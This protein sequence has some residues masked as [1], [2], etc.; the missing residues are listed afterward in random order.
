MSCDEQ[1]RVCPYGIHVGLYKYI[2]LLHLHVTWIQKS[3]LFINIIIEVF[4]MVITCLHSLIETKWT[5]CYLLLP[6]PYPSCSS[7][8]LLGRWQRPTSEERS[9]HPGCLSPKLNT[10]LKHSTSWWDL[11]SIADKYIQRA[12]QWTS[13]QLDKKD[14]KAAPRTTSS[15]S[16]SVLAP[17][18]FDWRLL[19]SL[20]CALGC[21]PCFYATCSVTS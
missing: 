1:D 5:I 19:L 7:R 8:C 12:L 16:P 9:I 6:A 2:Q 15:V 4:A 13:A 21:G 18:C 14:E 17:L 20:L 3:M 11:L 10:Q